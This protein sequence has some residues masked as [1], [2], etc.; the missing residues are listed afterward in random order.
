VHRGKSRILILDGGS[1][2]DHLVQKALEGQGYDA[3]T[4]HAEPLVAERTVC[5]APDLILALC[6]SGADAC[7]VC[8][9]IRDLSP[10]PIIALIGSSELADR[11]EAL[12]AGA[13]DCVS[14]PF[15]MEELLARVRAALRR[16]ELSG[17]DICTPTLKV[18]QLAIDFEQRRVLVEGSEVHLTA[19]ECRLLCLLAR[20]R[21]QV[22]PQDYLLENVW[23]LGYAGAPHL[24]WT[25]VHRLRE[26][27]ESDP[28]DPHIVQTVSGVGYVLAMRDASGVLLS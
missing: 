4:S 10:V 16:T 13:D 19:I 23:G 20:H 8:R 2:Y 17:A 24:L 5:S 22:L 26:K 27:I 9:A 12:D 3:I 14:A 18:G 11:L 25:A 7:K 15:A 28:S 1:R 21:G 6:R